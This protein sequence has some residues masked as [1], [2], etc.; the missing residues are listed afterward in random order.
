MGRA[1]WL[2]GESLGW[3]MERILYTPCRE[4]Y[5]DSPPRVYISQP[6]QL[7]LRH[8]FNLIRLGLSTLLGLQLPVAWIHARA[9]SSRR[10]AGP[11]ASSWASRKRPAGYTP[12][13]ISPSW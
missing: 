3:M 7:R 9:W 8:S 12:V 11:L 6:N 5:I 2:G 10:L 1:R 13:G 4:V